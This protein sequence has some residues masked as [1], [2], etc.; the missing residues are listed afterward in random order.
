MLW[1]SVWPD[2]GENT[3]ILKIGLNPL[4]INTAVAWEFEFFVL[5]V[6]SLEFIDHL[7]EIV[8]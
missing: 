2:G 5:S 4:I 6:V 3:L 8:L 1:A 7:V